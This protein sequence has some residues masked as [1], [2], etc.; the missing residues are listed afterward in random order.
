MKYCYYNY[1][2]FDCWLFKFDKGEGL[3]LH[4]HFAANFHDT[5]VLKGSCEIS[6]PDKKWA[7]IVNENERYDFTDEEMHHQITAL[8]PNT[9]VLNVYRNP[10]PACKYYADKGWQ[11]G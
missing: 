10:M 8:V 4:E 11:E 7:V 1:N 5:I 9:E 6:G 2:G 3:G